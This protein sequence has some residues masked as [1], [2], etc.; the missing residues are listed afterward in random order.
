MFPFVRWVLVL[1]R[2]VGQAEAVGRTPLSVT[3]AALLRDF[4]EAKGDQFADRRCNGMP[5]D[6]VVLKIVEGY[7]EPSVVH[8]AVVSQLYF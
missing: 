6:T 7:R 5:I 3:G 1:G 4:D 8:S 2:L